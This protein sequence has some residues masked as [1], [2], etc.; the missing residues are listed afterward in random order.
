GRGPPR[1]TALLTRYQRTRAAAHRER[2][3][4]PPVDGLR[5]GGLSPHGFLRIPGG[6]R[7]ATVPVD[8]PEQMRLR[9]PPRTRGTGRCRSSPQTGPPQDEGFPMTRPLAHQRIPRR[10]RFLAAAAVV[11][12]LAGVLGRGVITAGGLPAGPG[13]GGGKGRG[14]G[15][16]GWP[17]SR[18]RSRAWGGKPGT[19]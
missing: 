5:R 9:S 16:S 14:G 17:G 10:T 7:F 12:V 8:E 6:M 2:A 19:R 1:T 3:P 13:R 11:T 18:G 4:P 15:R